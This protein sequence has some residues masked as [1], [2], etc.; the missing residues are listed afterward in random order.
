MAKPQNLA[1][2][3]SVCPPAVRDRT[4]DALLTWLF[5]SEER[6]VAVCEQSAFYNVKKSIREIKEMP[7]QDKQAWREAVGKLIICCIEDMSMLNLSH[8]KGFDA[9]HRITCEDIC[10]ISDKH[11]I[12]KWVS[13][14]ENGFTTGLA[15]I[16]LN[17]TLKNMLLMEQFDE[18]LDVC[19]KHLHVPVSGFI[20][21][22]A[23][24]D[25]GIKMIDK[26]GQFNLYS[27]AD[28]K[29]WSKWDY[30]EY[31]GFQEEI[32]NAAD[33]PIDWEFN[34]WNKTRANRENK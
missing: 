15:Q 30:S 12:P 28:T 10:S 3:E 7:E 1:F 23:S 13:W 11:N 2:L 5:H 21:E 16:W 18:Q 26:H 22:A 4:Y 31:I 8:R 20:L 6:T 19:K 25:F 14:M 9:W 27:L 24:K 32:R 17:M 33:C 34:A 29:P